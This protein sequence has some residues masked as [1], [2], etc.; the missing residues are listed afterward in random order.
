MSINLRRNSKELHTVQIEL[1]VKK[2]DTTNKLFSY[3]I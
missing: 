1:L 2:N 3:E